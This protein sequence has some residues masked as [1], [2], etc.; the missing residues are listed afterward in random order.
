MEYRAVTPVPELGRQGDRRGVTVARARHE[1]GVSVAQR[2]AWRRLWR[3]LLQPVGQ[4]EAAVGKTAA[5]GKEDR[6]EK[7]DFRD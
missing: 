3:L 6:D 4:E 5:A 2:E 7:R 1:S